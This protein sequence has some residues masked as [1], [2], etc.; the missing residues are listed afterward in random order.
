MSVNVIA[1]D[2][3]Y[4]LGR[5]FVFILFTFCSLYFQKKKNNEEDLVGF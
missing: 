3:D 2:L 5:P 4:G 1:I